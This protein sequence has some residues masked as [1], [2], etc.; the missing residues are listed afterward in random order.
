MEAKLEQIRQALEHSWDEKT[1]YQMVRQKG[2]PAL[3]QCYP[4]ARLIQLFFP[5]VEIVEGEVE[6]GSSIEKHFGNLLVKDSAEL[7]INL[8]W[9]QFPDSA[10]VKSWWVRERETLGD[11]QETFDR[12]QLLFNRVDD[13]LVGHALFS[14][15][16]ARSSTNIS[17]NQ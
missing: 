10:K 1:S 12:V 14:D 2:N 7:H 8:T 17:L 11:S 5:E 4:T 6:V 9:Q 3:G 16:P 15:Q 13:R